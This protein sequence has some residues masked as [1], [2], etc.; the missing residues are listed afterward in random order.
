MLKF[1][2]QNTLARGGG[3]SK[4]ISPLIFYTA[5]TMAE[6]LITLGIIGI[7]AAMTL[8][9]LIQKQQTKSIL[10]SLN[11]SYA[12]LQNIVNLISNEHGEDIGNVIKLYDDEQTKNLF[13]KYYDNAKDC[14]NNSCYKEDI[15]YYTY[16]G[17]KIN[18]TT[19]NTPNSNYY[20]SKNK[21]ITKEGR[22]IIFGGT[23]K[24]GRMISVDVNGPFK[25]PNAWGRDVFTFR[26]ME[27]QIMPCGGKIGCSNP[28]N[29]NCNESE[30]GLY[31]G[32]GC[33]YYA[34][35]KPGF[36]DTK[37]YYKKYTAGEL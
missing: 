24:H 2:K 21:F 22:L 26:V 13:M 25:K 7:V 16:A 27:K 35:T 6:V 34:L 31:A 19:G 36:L 4:S 8:P 28:Y 9:A 15:I 17:D 12:E 29:Y 11:K 37:Y 30:K 14:S 1:I 18:I 10:V 3:T 20:F 32:L 33:T 5:F 23:N